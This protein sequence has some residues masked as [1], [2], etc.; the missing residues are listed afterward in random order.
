MQSEEEINKKLGRSIARKRKAVGYTQD[1]VSLHLD[2]GREA[3]SRIERGITGASVAKLY[4]LAELFGCEVEAFFTEANRSPSQQVE[5][6]ERQL[7]KLSSSEQK[8]LVRIVEALAPVLK[9]IS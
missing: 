3:Y 1:D 8:L 5:A 7:S 2:I 4:A 6:V 9:K